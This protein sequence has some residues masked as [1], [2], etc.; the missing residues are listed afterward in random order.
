ML[1]AF[2]TIVHF[3]PTSM[4]ECMILPELYAISDNL[5][6]IYVYATSIDLNQV[7]DEYSIY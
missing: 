5:S 4:Y 2:F 7:K 3:W 1:R 6:Y